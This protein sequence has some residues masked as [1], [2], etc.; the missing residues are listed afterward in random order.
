MYQPHV[1]KKVVDDSGNTVQEINPV[2][3]KETVSQEVSDTLRDY[4]YTVV[5]EGTGAKA[6]VE[7]YA[8]GGKTGTAEKVP[9]GSGNYVVSFIGYAPVED[10]QVVVYV[11]V[12]VPHVEAQDHCSQSSFIAKNIFSQ[13]LPYLNIERMESAATE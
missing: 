13:I 1:V 5:S 6:A 8:I 2:V 9:R 4:M 7:G 3:L 10:P 12:D 11:V